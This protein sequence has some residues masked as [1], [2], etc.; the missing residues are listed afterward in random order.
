MSLATYPLIAWGTPE[1]ISASPWADAGTPIVTGSIA[2]PFGG[3]S[4]YTIEDND[5]AS[6]E[7]RRVTFT[8]AGDG[9][10]WVVAFVKAGTATSTEVGLW[11]ATAGA[12]RGQ[13]LLTW[14]GGV[15]TTTAATGS[16]LT[17]IACG[18]G[19]YCQIMGTTSAT[20]SA[21]S[22]YLYLYPAGAQTADTG[23]ASFYVRNAVLLDYVD[24]YRRYADKRVGYATVEGGSGVRDAWD[25]GTNYHRRGTVQYIPAT[26]RD[27]PVTVSGF[28]G[29][30]E[31]TGVNCGVEAM[32]LAGMQMTSMVWVP[33][34]SDC[35]TNQSVYLTSPSAGWEPQQ[36]PNGDFGFEMELVTATDPGAVP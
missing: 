17:P 6:N 32:L 26:P 19:W 15:P 34:R 13:A 10:Q 7:G 23:T 29:G 24:N 11:D 4:A 2:D 8:L 16:V 31:A 21:N 25:Q 27:A 36:Q 22:N 20:V 35:A 1:D 33:D 30:N 12:W 18:S 9:V 3:T 14:S 28:L 5:G